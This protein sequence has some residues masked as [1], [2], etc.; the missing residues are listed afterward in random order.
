MADVILSGSSS[1]GGGTPQTNEILTAYDRQA[2]FALREGTV[3]DPFAKFRPGNLT[4]PGNPVKVL[5][6]ADMSVDTTALDEIV[7]VEAK[8]LSTSF[9]T[10]TPKEYGDALKLTIRLRTDNFTIG[11][12]ADVAN[13][14]S[15]NMVEKIDLLARDALDGGSNEDYVGVST[16]SFLTASNS[17]SATE[18]RQKHAEIRGD[19][20]VPVAGTLYVAVVHPDCAFDLKQET[21]DA[22]WVT[23]NK[24]V[25]TPIFNNELGTFGGFRF[26]ESPRAKINDGGGST[27]VDSYTNYFMGAE[28]LAKVESIAPHMVLGPVTDTLKRIQPLGWYFYAGW[29]TLREAAVRRLLSASTIGANS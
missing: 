1:S 2:M 8:S 15:W 12:D 21:G 22:A 16:E 4:S 11:Y 27:T 18:V 10:I 23:P 24:Y 26:I 19:S 28:A 25:G 13:I 9:V 29:D 20:V 5:F 7:D 14:L 3:F 6:R 17:L